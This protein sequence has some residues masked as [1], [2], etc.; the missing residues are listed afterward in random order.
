MERVGAGSHK[1]VDRFATDNHISVVRFGKDDRKV[2][3]MQP[4]LSR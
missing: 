2:D 4:Y 1:A 3:R